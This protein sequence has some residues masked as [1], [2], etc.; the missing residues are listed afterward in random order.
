MVDARVEKLPHLPE[1]PPSHSFRLRRCAASEWCRVHTFDT[2]TGRFQPDAFNDTTNGNARFSP[3][4]DPDTNKVIPTIYAAA[5]EAGAISE[6]I[7]HDIPTPS[8]G[9]LHDWESDKAG[10]QHLSRI[11]LP[12]LQLVDLQQGLQAAGLEQWELFGTD[13]PDYPRTRRWA[14]HIWKTM[15]DAAGLIWMSKR[16]NEGAA[17]ML[18][19]DRVLP[20]T[21]TVS[22]SPAPIAQFEA[23]VL[24]I[25][26]RLGCGL[27]L[28]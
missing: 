7:L 19:G 17:L 9:Y 1:P 12:D 18:F 20:G 26:D 6:V 10:K 21:I 22:A 8:T 13:K 23:S 4:I 5:T 14:L 3:L 11:R 2:A 25:L 24:A 27:A 28:S 16:A 15:P